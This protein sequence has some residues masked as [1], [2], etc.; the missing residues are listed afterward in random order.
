MCHAFGSLR[1]TFG[2]EDGDGSMSSGEKC[3][4]QRRQP[5]EDL[6][7]RSLVRCLESDSTLVLKELAWI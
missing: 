1:V 3:D 7:A 5:N 2:E 6:V 4:R